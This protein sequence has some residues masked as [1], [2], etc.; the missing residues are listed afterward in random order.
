MEFIA[1]VRSDDQV[2]QSV[3]Q[4]LVDAKILAEDWGRPLGLSNVCGLAALLHDMGKYSDAFQHYIRRAVSGEKVKRGEV[5]HATAGGRLLFDTLK[6]KSSKQLLAEIVSNAIISHHGNLH[7][8]VQ[9][10]DSPFLQRVEVKTLEEYEVCKQRFFDEVISE[11][12]FNDYVEVAHRQL[13]SYLKRIGATV[14]NSSFLTKLIFS[15]LIDADR[16]NTRQF[17]ENKIDSGLTDYLTVYKGRLEQHITR[18]STSSIV[19][20]INALR[21]KMS[22]QAMHHAKQPSGIYTLS[23]PTG[24]G[25]TL[26]SLRYALHHAIHYQKRRI[27]YVVPFTT[28][29]EQNAQVARAVLKTNEIVE[30]H[31][32]VVQLDD[33]SEDEMNLQS[34]LNLAKDNWDAPIIFTTM[35]QYLNTF[36][37]KG[38][39]NTRRLHHLS[40]AIVIFDEVQKVPTKCV[41]LFNES[42]NFLKNGLSS[43]VILCTATQPALDFVKHRL[44]S[45]GEMIQDLPVVVEAFKRTEIEVLSDGFD[46]DRLGLFVQDKVITN[47][48]VLIILNTKTVVRRLYESLKASFSEDEVYHLSTSMCAAHRKYIL[49]KINKRLDTGK[50][51]ICISTQLIEAGV[52]VSFQCVIR[53][54]AGL[55]SIAQAAGRCNRHGE[56]ERRTVYLINHVEESVS[57]LTDIAKGQEIVKRLV[58]DLERDSTAYGGELLSP[59]A[60]RRYF[61]EF[62]QLREVDLDYAVKGSTETLAPMLFEGT[63][64]RHRISDTPLL[65]VA[66]HR[67]V[68]DNFHV[69]EQ[70]TDDVLVPYGDK[71][72][73]LIALLN[74]D[75]NWEDA[76]KWLKESQQYTIS[77]YNHERQALEQSGGIV[78]LLDGRLLVLQPTAYDE[79]YGLNLSQDSEMQRLIM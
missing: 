19:S 2:I 32:N 64:N 29:I 72:K 23:I 65:L 50:R 58:V 27:I 9:G 40:E 28:I 20:P 71:G 77:I 34:K 62:Y 59:L 22:E 78:S 31:S 53:S 21:Q 12:D 52:D 33:V 42:L 74:G 11:V 51:V 54:F 16:T 69:I 30:H 8:Y 37:A 36:Y 17:E 6:G 10:E 46:T 76:R 5:D 68:A 79:Q 13:W 39:R 47:Q 35:V 45:D 73:E 41:S 44:T 49:E 75:V 38:N 55:D 63:K 4:H 7:D 48:S 56:V 24:G 3:R 1:H 15:I 66:R 26:A 60:M 57:K 18:L 43:S 14:P 70:L 61:Q 67:T 25:K